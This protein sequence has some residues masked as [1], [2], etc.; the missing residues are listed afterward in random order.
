MT[1]VFVNQNKKKSPKLTNTRKNTRVAT[2]KRKF[3]HFYCLHAKKQALKF[4]SEHK[5]FIYLLFTLFTCFMFICL[6][7]FLDFK[8]FSLDHQRHCRFKTRL[9]SVLPKGLSK[10]A[11][12]WETMKIQHPSFNSKTWNCSLET[13]FTYRIW[14]F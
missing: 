13:Y 7:F 10:D 3:Y 6:C 9:K 14:I 1:K 8:F 12:R 11:I 4:S 2:K 5:F